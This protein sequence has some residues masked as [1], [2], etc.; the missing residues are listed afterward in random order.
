MDTKLELLGISNHWGLQLFRYFLAHAVIAALFLGFPPEI[1]ATI[2]AGNVENCNSFQWSASQIQNCSI[3][4]IQR[5]KK[6]REWFYEIYLELSIKLYH[7]LFKYFYSTFL[8]IQLTS[9]CYK[10]NETKLLRSTFITIKLNNKLWRLLL[11]V[12][13]SSVDG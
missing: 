8:N 6:K 2:H 4:L 12:Q 5:E 1:G 9:N 7:E 11:S 13:N 3:T 10:T